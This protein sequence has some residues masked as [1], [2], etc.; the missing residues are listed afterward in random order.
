MSWASDRAREVWEPRIERIRRAWSNVEWLAVVE[1]VRTCALTMLSPEQYVAQAGEWARQ[2]LSSL[3]MEIVGGTPYI[4]SSTGQEP[5]PGQPIAFRIVVGTPQN[6]AQFKGAWDANDQHRI[7]RLLGYPACCQEFFRQVWVE[8]GMV[9]TTWPMAANGA[10]AETDCVEVA[11]PVE[12]NILWRWVGVRAVSHLPCRF[13]CQ[14]SVELAHKL[15]E[16]GRRAGYGPEMAWLREMLAWPVEWA[17]L[18]GIAEIKT[19]ILKVVARTDATAGKYTVRRQGTTYPAEGAHGIK[20][21]Y[22]E[23]ENLPQTALLEPD[24]YAPDNGFSSAQAMAEAHQPLVGLAAATLAGQEGPVLDL[25]C[26]NGAL[27]QRIHQA[28]PKLIPF[29]IE[30]EPERVAHAHQLLPEFAANFRQGNI[31]TDAELWANGHRYRLAILMPG[32]LLEAKPEQARRLR[33]QLKQHCD[34]LLVYA[35][36]DWLS[37][38]GGLPGLAEQAGLS[39]LDRQTGARFG[40]AQVK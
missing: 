15:L 27:L 11:G 3:P 26:G 39:L 21:P 10:T 29:G 18:H 32:R 4:Y 23:G 19:P 14:P 12:A 7:G 16:V 9:D 24:W 38:C 17:A 6:M 28:H 13:D 8:Q 35:Y 20:F 31:F 22:Q 36:G 2:G 5:T 25:G 1:G 34:H 33:E 40:L 37:R 30:L